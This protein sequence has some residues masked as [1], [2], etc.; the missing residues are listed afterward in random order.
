MFVYIYICRITYTFFFITHLDFCIGL[1]VDIDASPRMGKKVMMHGSCTKPQWF[2]VDSMK[3]DVY[4]PWQFSHLDF[5]EFLTGPGNFGIPNGHPLRTLILRVNRT[6][7]SQQSKHRTTMLAVLAAMV[8]W[9][10]DR[11]RDVDLFDR[12]FDIVDLHYSQNI[13]I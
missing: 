5:P 9:I 8:F 10:F 3:F 13:Y 6:Q 1:Q 7:M 4:I 11:L 12:F 2:T